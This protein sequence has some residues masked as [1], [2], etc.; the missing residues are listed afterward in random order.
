MKILLLPIVLVIL[1]S[2]CNND[3]A[4]MKNEETTASV[5]KEIDVQKMSI[6]NLIT[7][8][9]NIENEEFYESKL[10][11][12]GF[13]EKLNAIYVLKGKKNDK[14]IHNIR[15]LNM[16]DM[17]TVAFST[18]DKEMWQMILEEIKTF[19]I[20]NEDFDDG[21]SFETQRMIGKDYTFET[22]I[23]ESISLTTN[24]LFEVIIFKTLD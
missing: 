17:S 13:E 3:K 16:G 5:E 1:L 9:D 2:N 10:D 11:S 23:P 7:I 21:T 14:S 20:K 12:L 6:Q 19:K 8:L 24:T 15:V 18:G 22:Y 4:T